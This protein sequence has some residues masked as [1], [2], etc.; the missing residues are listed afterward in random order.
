MINKGINPQP[1]DLLAEDKKPV[2]WIVAP[3]VVGSNPITHPNI[4][5]GLRE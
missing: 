2:N 4:I 5:K 1:F 3:G